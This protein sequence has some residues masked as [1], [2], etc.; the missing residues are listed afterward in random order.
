MF[1]K[2]INEKLDFIIEQ[3]GKNLEEYQKIMEEQGKQ[4]QDYKN[5]VEILKVAN[6][7]LIENQK[8]NNQSLLG[9]QE[10]KLE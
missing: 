10:K 9:K 7:E 8:E 3:Q 6:R 5:L 2:K 1:F 4:I